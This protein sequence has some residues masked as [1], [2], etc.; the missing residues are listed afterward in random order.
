[1]P[2]ILL[3]KSIR[4]IIVGIIATISHLSVQLNLL[5]HF[6]LWISNMVG[7]FLGSLVSYFGH[8]LFTFQEITAAT[9]FARRWLFL[10]FTINVSISAFIPFVFSDYQENLFLSLRWF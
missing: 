4:Y 2:I 3:K 1:M 6:P 10:Q 5:A 8:S 7:F 9:I